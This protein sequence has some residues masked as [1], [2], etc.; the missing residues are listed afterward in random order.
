MNEKQCMI[1]NAAFKVFARF[2]VKKTSIDDIAKA[3]DISRQGVYLHF[4]NKDEIFKA[5]I[6]KYFDD[7]SRA[8]LATLKGGG[9]PAE[10]L[11][12]ALFEW[13]GKSIG[14][15]HQDANDVIEEGSVLLKPTIEAYSKTFRLALAE[16]IQANSSQ[17]RKNQQRSED[18]AEIL[19]ACGLSWKHELNSQDEFQTRMKRTINLLLLLSTPQ[20]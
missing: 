1:L 20:S 16:T 3:A 9:K 10:R 12:A 14:L 15:I 19:Y 17:S 4:K 18:L 2:G 13:F 6:E 5:S 7:Q 11:E 8:A